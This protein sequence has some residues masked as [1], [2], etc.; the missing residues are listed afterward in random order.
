[1]DEVTKVKVVVIFEESVEFQPS[2]AFK[3]TL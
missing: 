1:M 3:N 2:F